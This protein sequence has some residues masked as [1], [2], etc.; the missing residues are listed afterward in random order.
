MVIKMLC[1]QCKKNIAS[2]KLE[3]KYN[4]K[5]T[6]LHLC[7]ECC[8]TLG[9]RY[10]N[11][12]EGNSL[13]ETT[14]QVKVKQCPNCKMTFSKYQETGLVGCPTCYV[15]FRE[16]LTPYI[17]KLQNNIKHVGKVGTNSVQRFQKKLSELQTKLQEA[18]SKQNYL[19]ADRLNKEI[20]TLKRQ[21]SEGLHE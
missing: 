14:Q 8:A 18:L 20:V 4:N 6:S 5:I 10:K 15:T 3:E 16:A 11:K 1:Q 9:S 21:I 19:E 13:G 2:I 7:K 12:Q 17:A